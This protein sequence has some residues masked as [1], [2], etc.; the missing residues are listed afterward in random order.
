[1]ISALE[2]ALLV[3]KVVRDSEAGEDYDEDASPDKSDI[4]YV[5]YFFKAFTR[6]VVNARSN[7]FMFMMDDEVWDMIHDD[8]LSEANLRKMFKE[9]L[10]SGK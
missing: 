10:D 6:D 8:D 5:T 2:L 9:N 7:D 3:L 1:M 4:N